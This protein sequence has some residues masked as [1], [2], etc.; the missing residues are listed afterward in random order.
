MTSCVSSWVWPEKEAKQRQPGKHKGPYKRVKEATNEVCLEP[1]TADC[2]SLYNCLH[3]S[4]QKPYLSDHLHFVLAF[5]VTFALVL[6]AF[7]FLHSVHIH[8]NCS[9]P[10]CPLNCPTP[11]TASIVCRLIAKSWFSEI[12]T[13]RTILQSDLQ[14]DLQLTTQPS[15][16]LQSVFP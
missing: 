3:L 4:F 6:L 11:S 5:R 2:H 15:W 12:F 16:G 9:V 8:R 14:I 7:F 10:E 1:K 13:T